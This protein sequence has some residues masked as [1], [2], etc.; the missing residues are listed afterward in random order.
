MAFAF[1]L[2]TIVTSTYNHAKYLKQAIDSVLNQDYPAIE[3]LVFND[4]SPDRTEDILKSYG[5]QFYWETQPNMGETPTLNKAVRMAKGQFVG[6]LSSDDFLYP[7]AIR[8]MVA[9]FLKQP[10]LVVVYS[11]FD[12]VDED[13]IKYQLIQK[14]DFHPL[15][16]IRKHLCLPGPGAL[17]RKEVFDQLDGF[18]TQFRILFDMDFWWRASLIGPF[19]RV[20]RSLAAFRQHRNSQSSMGGLR[21]SNET[22]QCVKKFYSL[23]N[24]PKRVKEIRGESFSS[25]YYSAAMQTILACQEKDV[26]RKMLMQ[27]FLHAPISYLKMENRGKLI[28]WLDVMISP[29]IVSG[30]KKMIK[31]Q[32][33]GE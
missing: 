31:K 21:M 10:N 24:L 30:I 19:A 26:P 17:F 27:S 15:D 28:G 4:G 22:I 29:K 12:L 9:E 3:Y 7:T 13:G 18:D 20:P 2:V 23:P 6:K 25:A 5:K 33:I 32:P 16:P 8:E 11:D 14:P 1:P